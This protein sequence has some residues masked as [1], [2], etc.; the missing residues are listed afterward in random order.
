MVV[1][2]SCRSADSAVKE[3]SDDLLP[4]SE[5]ADFWS[6]GG[7]LTTYGPPLAAPRRSNG[8]LRQTFL[9]VEM[10]YDPED[11]AT[12]VRLAPLGWELGL[13]EPAVPPIDNDSSGYDPETG[14]TLYAG[15]AQLYKD[16]GGKP[17]VG[18]PI[19]DVAFRDGQIIQYFE[20]L[21][22]TRPE[23]ASPADTRL[24]ALGLA[25][26]PSGVSFGVDPQAPVV[27][28]LI[29]ERPFAR[30]LEPLGGETIFGQPISNPYLAGDGALEQVY[31]RAV[32]FSPDGSNRNAAFRPLGSRQGAAQEPAAP[33]EEG[34]ALFFESTGHN[35]VWA[36]ADFYREHQGEVT[37][38]MPLEEMVLG[39]NR[40]RQRFENNVLEYR[41]DLPSQLAVQLAPLG[42]AYLAENPPPTAAPT[43]VAG[44]QE[45]QPPA[46]SVEPGAIRLV[47]ALGSA[48]L[49]PDSEQTLEIR[50]LDENDSPVQESTVTIRIVTRNRDRR[51]TL[52]PTDDEGT[53]RLVWKDGD[54]VPGEIVSVL[55]RAVSTGRTAET[56][57]QYAHGFGTPT[58]AEP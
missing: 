17:V 4:A 2:A 19:T 26:R 11:R 15:F 21:G 56:L 50:I 3:G 57:L 41:F 12:P 27:S 37:L 13:A 43:E 30:F 38:G 24:V 46:Q 10:I 16:L 44:E 55:V 14:H 40:M 42:R 36:F 1:L 9:A 52:P 20:N 6:R 23:N 49:D 54:A 47:A 7:G 32:V 5:F 51:Q 35:V 8:V 18:A 34:G 22:M 45:S 25:A 39:D 53:T 31:E 58:T 48:V 29:R 33:S 28:D